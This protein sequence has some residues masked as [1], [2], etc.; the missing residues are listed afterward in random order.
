MVYFGWQ[1]VHFGLFANDMVTQ[2]NDTFIVA[3][4]ATSLPNNEEF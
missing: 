1:I 4:N 2:R 3:Y